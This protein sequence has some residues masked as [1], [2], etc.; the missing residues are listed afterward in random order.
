MTNSKATGLL[1]LQLATTVL[2]S[3][4]LVLLARTGELLTGVTLMVCVFPCSLGNGTDQQLVKYGRSG[5]RVASREACSVPPN[6]WYAGMA[7]PSGFGI[8]A[9]NDTYK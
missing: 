9:V 5:A 2:I 3:C 7:Q 8:L 1:G 4:C 6:P